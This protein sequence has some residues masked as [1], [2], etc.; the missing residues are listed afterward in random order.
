MERQDSK[1]FIA[2][3]C[4]STKRVFALSSSDAFKVKGEEWV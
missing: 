4:T 3:G 1:L 2:A